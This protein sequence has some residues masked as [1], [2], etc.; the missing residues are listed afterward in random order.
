[1]RPIT[2]V[3]GTPHGGALQSTRSL[4]A[5]AREAGHPVRFLVMDKDPYAAWRRTIG[6]LETARQAAPTLGRVGWRA[7]DRAI[8]RRPSD[9]AQEQRVT[10]L[11][12]SLAR[13]M[14]P[15][16]LL[17]VNSV[18]GLELSRLADLAR[19]RGTP[20]VWYI[21]EESSLA[22]LA[23]YGSHV[24]LILAN[25]MPLARQVEDRAGRECSYVPSVISVDDLRE[26][27]N[28]AKILLVNAAPSHGSDELLAMAAAAP[29]RRFVLQESWPLHEQ[30]FQAL[31]RAIDGRPN[32]E[33][34][35]RTHRSRVYRDARIM[36]APYAPEATGLSRP[37]V[38]LECQ[39]LGVP[40]I[41]YSTEGLSAVAASPDLLL[42]PGSDEGRWLAAID[43][44]DDEYE[45]YSDRARAFATGELPSPQEVWRRFVDACAPLLKP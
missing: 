1:M 8:G 4:V 6:A 27:D 43:R 17:V 11:T 13:A 41:A 18:R 26:P 33:I 30:Q 36:L 35:H 19:V 5:A 38:A 16:E 29:H 28:R 31:V 3:C 24:D 32:V 25:S 45:L 10:N 21:R 2:F 40:L 7:F 39:Y 44:V 12:G 9:A 20:F 22:H 37:R 34:R 15:G 14:R 42:P 23:R